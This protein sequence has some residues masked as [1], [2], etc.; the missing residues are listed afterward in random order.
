MSN[1]GLTCVTDGI[2]RIEA[3]LNGTCVSVYI[4][5]GDRLAVLDA[6]YNFHPEELIIPGLKSLGFALADVELIINTHGH[7]DHL[8][9]NA[10]LR[11]LTGAKTCLHYADAHLAAGPEAH[12]SSR[13][14]PISAMLALG[15]DRQVAERRVY[16]HER[17]DACAID[18]QLRDYD[19][20]A[21]GNGL[22]LEV[23]PTP[24]HTDGSVTL[25]ARSRRLAFAGD[26]IQVW[27][28]AP[29]VLPLYY[30]PEAYRHS[31]ALLSSLEIDTLC[32]AHDF[33]WSKSGTVS[34]PVR[35]GV[36]VNACLTESLEFVDALE[37]LTCASEPTGPMVERVKVVA[38]RLPAPFQLQVL[39]DGTF[40]AASA[41]TIINSLRASDRRSVD[42][43]RV[44]KQ[45]HI[46]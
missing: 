5:K 20:L 16:L 36:D 27:G 14:D 35:S 33:R 26:A 30:D 41:S 22:D 15:W 8:G 21:L 31:L 43:D 19:V 24:G 18:R 4:V 25:Y 46:G 10:V 34:G 1:M 42:G 23:I 44:V 38:A 2:W 40:S 45:L 29:G 28:V 17:I 12:I 9:G 39:P 6:G 13:T 37:Q 32:L 3:R 7:P 11:R